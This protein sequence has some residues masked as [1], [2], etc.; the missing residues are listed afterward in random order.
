MLLKTLA[1]IFILTLSAI[2]LIACGGSSSSDP[3]SDRDKVTQ[4]PTTFIYSL[5]DY[6][7]TIDLPEKGAQVGQTIFAI[8]LTDNFSNPQAGITPTI[9]PMMDMGSYKHSSPH[10]GCT[11]T[12]AEGNAN[13]TVY[14]NMASVSP[15]GDSMGTW[16]I[17]ITLPGTQTGNT[18]DGSETITFTP[19]VNMAMDTTR[20][21]K[22]RG[23]L[24][25]QAPS[26]N[27]KTDSRQYLIFNNGISVNDSISGSESSNNKSVELF[28][29]AK[30]T[31]M[32]FPALTTGL[33]LNEDNHETE[34]TVN[35]ITVK[36]SADNSTW[37]TATSDFSEG[38]EGS[39][40]IWIADNISG[41][42]N[43]LYVSLTVNGETKTTDGEVAG[44]ENASAMFVVS[45][46]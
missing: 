32:N 8:N 9:K 37:T 16:N 30:E 24:D 22:L 45:G 28:I 1:Q 2:A 20:V 27:G 15:N 34:L 29:A 5:K 40:G 38:G 42:S 3:T 6:T 36:V 21:A 31:M 17:D 41:L 18:S 4:A 44:T 12:D 33:I 46:M 26:M 13:C 25:D 19:I 11:K 7:L 39:E 14:F 23:G 43:E 35:S 10:S